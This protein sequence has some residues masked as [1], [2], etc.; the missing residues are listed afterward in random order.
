LVAHIAAQ[1]EHDPLHPNGFQTLD[2]HGMTHRS[3]IDRDDKQTR[4]QGHGKLAEQA[5]RCFGIL[6]DG[7]NDDDLV[8]R[9]A[10]P[11][12]LLRK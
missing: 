1:S 6:E 11:D 10:H 4:S 7:G 5:C 3:V 9:D 12:T 8:V 2:E